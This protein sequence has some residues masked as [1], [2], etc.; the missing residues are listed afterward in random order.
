MKKSMPIRCA[1]YAA[2]AILLL[3]ILAAAVSPSAYA[4]ELKPDDKSVMGG[5][6]DTAEEL[7]MDAFRPTGDAAASRLSAG[8]AGRRTDLP[9]DWQDPASAKRVE[10]HTPD[11]VYESDDIAIDTEM[12]EI[13]VDADGTT[14]LLDGNNVVAYVDPDAPTVYPATACEVVFSK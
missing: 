9:Y 3:T 10:I 2:I 14:V 4:M 11:G 1:K 8:N 5:S 12:G 13:T 7:S 6:A